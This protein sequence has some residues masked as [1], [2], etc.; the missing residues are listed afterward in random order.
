MISRS[1]SSGASSDTYLLSNLRTM[2]VIALALD[3]LYVHNKSITM[4]FINMHRRVN[5]FLNVKCYINCGFLAVSSYFIKFVI[6]N[7]CIMPYNI[8]YFEVTNFYHNFMINTKI[9]ISILNSSVL[10]FNCT[11]G[12]Y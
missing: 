2:S 3:R 4:L 5:A 11:L 7:N 1:T 10:I 6:G 8:H 12:K 9:P